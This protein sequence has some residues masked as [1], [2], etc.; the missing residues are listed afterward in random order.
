MDRYDQYNQ[1][2]SAIQNYAVVTNDTTHM[3]NTDNDSTTCME[4]SGGIFIFG[5]V[6][7]I[8]LPLISV[9]ISFMP[10]MN[11]KFTKYLTTRNKCHIVIIGAL[12]NLLIFLGCLGVLRIEHYLDGLLGFPTSGPCRFGWWTVVMIMWYMTV[13]CTSCGFCSIVTCLFAKRDKLKYQEVEVITFGDNPDDMT[14]TTIFVTPGCDKVTPG[15]NN[16]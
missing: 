13:L 8:L 5:I 14:S 11:D 16:V 7:I 9:I 10:L 15:E 12:I 6:G 4:M 2:T 1:C 3:T